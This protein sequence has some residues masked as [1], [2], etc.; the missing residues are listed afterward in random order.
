MDFK[1]YYATLG[2]E[3]NASQE[4]IK[5]QYRTLARQYHPDLNQNAEA[6][7]RFK[8]IN[9][10][11]E[12]LGDPDKRA[13]Y[14]RYGSAWQSVQEGA[15]PPPG[16]ED[17]F[18]AFDGAPA[19]EWGYSPFSSFFDFLFGDAQNRRG[20]TASHNAPWAHRDT[21]YEAAVSLTLEE[22]A[23]GGKRQL[24]LPDPATGRHKTYAVNFPKGMRP[25]Q[26]IR[27][28][29]QGGQGGD[30]YLVVQLNRTRASASKTKRCTPP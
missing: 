11:Y 10:A 5:R 28:A 21:D 24:S 15:A 16:Y 12:V 4:D 1:D 25:G 22:A 19:A 6:E 20:R 13:K 7:V 8:E 30:L 14:D 23:A 17:F 29:G 9:E 27:L 26:R 2:V 3:C 18:A